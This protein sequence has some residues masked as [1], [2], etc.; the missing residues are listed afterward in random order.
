MTPEQ[1]KLVQDSFMLLKRCPR[2]PAELFYKRLFEIAPQ[3]RPLFPDNMDEQKIKFFM[4]LN[5]TILNLKNLDILVP[6]IK[7]MGRRHVG[8]GVTVDQFGAVKNAFFWTLEEALGEWYSADVRDAWIATYTA[9][10]GTMKAG[11][12]SEEL[13]S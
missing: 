12:E 13:S 4:M 8:Y 9:L 11:M 10:E 5:S 6:S 3:V 2:D 7:A 1:T